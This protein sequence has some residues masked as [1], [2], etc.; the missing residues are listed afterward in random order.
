MDGRAVEYLKLQKIATQ[1]LMASTRLDW[2]IMSALSI[3]DS[4]VDSPGDKQRLE[5]WNQLQ[6]LDLSAPRF[7]HFTLDQG[8][9]SLRM[10]IVFEGLTWKTN[11]PTLSPLSLHFSFLQ[12]DG[13]WKVVRFRSVTANLIQDFLATES[14]TEEQALWEREGELLASEEIEEFFLRFSLDFQNPRLGR[15]EKVS[16]PRLSEEVPVARVERF[17][18]AIAD[19]TNSTT[20][21]AEAFLLLGHLALTRGNYADAAEQL[22]HSLKLAE[23]SHDTWL[24]AQ[25]RADLARVYVH[26]NDEAQ[27]QTYEHQS[28]NIFL[29]EPR[30][31]QRAIAV[32]RAF[33]AAY[34]DTAKSNRAIEE[35][36]K[37]VRLA[38]EAKDLD[39]VAIF[40]KDLGDC[41]SQLG[42]YSKA[43]TWFR[44]S[45]SVI[46]DQQGK[47][48]DLHGVLGV[49]EI[50][51][52]L[53]HTL[54]KQGG[55]YE[56]ATKFFD[57]AREAAIQA[58]DT[59]GVISAFTAMSDYYLARNELKSSID[60]YEQMFVAL[61]G[62]DGLGHLDETFFSFVCGLAI[63]SPRSP[64][65]RSFFS[66]LIKSYGQQ[67]SPR[68]FSLLTV[69]QGELF[70]LSGEYGEAENYLKRIIRQPDLHSEIRVYALVDL[71]NVYSLQGQF[72]DAW[73]QIKLAE[74]IARDLDD[75][76]LREFIETTKAWVMWIFTDGKQSIQRLED[77][78]LHSKDQMTLGLAYAY[79]GAIY[80]SENQAEK[81]LTQ[82][83]KSLEYLESDNEENNPFSFVPMFLTSLAYN[84]SGNYEEALR[85]AKRASTVA[86]KSSRIQMG[87]TK[88]LE[89]MAYRGL[90]RLNEARTALEESIRITEENRSQT[91]GG[92]PGAIS[93][94]ETMVQPYQ[95]MLDVLVESGN[96]DR[97]VEL[98]ESTKAR[99]LMDILGAGS[100]KKSALSRVR[101][102]QGIANSIAVR[103]YLDLSQAPSSVAN[104]N[105]GPPITSAEAIALL[106]DRD[107]AVLEYAVNANQV[108]LFVLTATPSSQRSNSQ[109]RSSSSWKI[110]RIEV[111]SEIL[112]DEI[113]KLR[114]LISENR[115]GF[116]EQGQKLY[117]LLVKPADADLAGKTSL[118]IVPDGILWGL[119]FQALQPVADH[120]LL[121]DF[122]ISYVQSLAV[123]RKMS[124]IRSRNLR[125]SSPVGREVLALGN[126]SNTPQAVE[127]SPLVM[128]A[129]S[130]EID[131]SGT[132]ISAPTFD[133]GAFPRFA[134]LKPLPGATE[135]A[136]RLQ[137]IYGRASV[138]TLVGPSATKEMLLREASRYRIIHLATHGILDYQNPLESAVF[139]GNTTT[140]VPA[141][142]PGHNPR[143]ESSRDRLLTGRE[144]MGMKLRAELVVLSACD[145]AGGGVSGGEGMI[146]LTWA[147]AAAGVPTVV[148]SQW[149]VNDRSTADL[150]TDFHRRL[151]ASSG[152]GH[153]RGTAAALRGA[154]LALARRSEYRHPYYWA[155]FIA[156]GDA[157]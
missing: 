63:K 44:R 75:E 124:D 125:G 110:H 108:Y 50:H 100:R 56:Q 1:F 103:Q 151:R 143:Y 115:S 5:N 47:P 116:S 51:L 99:A 128:N 88:V 149:A 48:P 59:G 135:E 106:P 61:K 94:F 119:P 152:G 68:S 150:M 156:V 153:V 142:D 101:T 14:I 144:V 137:A 41:Y 58:K 79:L 90:H 123:L 12:K 118:I 83:K 92:I 91:A 140:A 53:G 87:R 25:A 46:G 70:L 9:A 62:I 139:F 40:Y 121:Q 27:A 76:V 114:E 95:L 45:L 22:L 15:F 6:H 74:Y 97:A 24:I 78:I 39:W 28:M 84:E 82:L 85:F 21:K 138:K 104:S 52:A 132:P 96:T 122:T 120:F 33:A 64:L 43:Q 23:E 18:N 148:A 55:T 71:A 26:T 69:L 29:G 32:H 13:V 129:V 31:Y 133:R 136:S 77:V 155:A 146:G 131:A 141:P 107:A 34:F 81:A 20:A 19:R 10:T 105:E 35:Y 130:T 109:W 65:V 127:I 3:D 30:D 147:F 157:R 7:S 113:D 111:S 2:D 117:N 126:S 67:M 57:R 54:E 93:F 86:Q 38:E 11:Q 42:D 17:S 72:D 89:A 112:G 36:E 80:L 66:D 4:S 154:A 8:R 37:G 134:M 98:A 73:T 102:N 16:L 60:N 145:T 49:W